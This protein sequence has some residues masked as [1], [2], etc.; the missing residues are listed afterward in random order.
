MET[1]R[2]SFEAGPRVKNQETLSKK[3]TKKALEVWLK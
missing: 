3:T 1:K 2:I